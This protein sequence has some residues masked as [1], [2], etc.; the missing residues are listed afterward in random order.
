MII[1]LDLTPSLGINYYRLKEIDMDQ[2]YTY[3]NVI[4]VNNEPFNNINISSINP[5]PAQNKFDLSFQ[6]PNDG[7]VAIDIYNTI[8]QKIFERKLQNIKKGAYKERIDIT[9]S[10]RENGMYLLKLG[11]QGLEKI[12]WLMLEQ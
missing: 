9:Q 6:I 4:Q 5:N 11:Q 2:S 8:G 3:S 1:G 10:P 12:K 7:D